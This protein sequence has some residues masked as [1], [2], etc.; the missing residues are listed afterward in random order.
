M[1]WT[2][3]LSAQQIFY[4]VF[5]AVIAVALHGFVT[6]GLARLLGDRG[7]QYDGRLTLNPFRHI[8]PIGMLCAVL[9]LFGWSRPPKIDPAELRFGRLALP[10]IVFA[11]ILTLIAFA[12]GLWALRPL[13]FSLMP[14][15]SVSYVAVGLLE[16]IAQMSVYMAV[17]N[18]LPL[19]PLGAGFLVLALAPAAYRWIEKR[20]VFFSIA[21]GA[22]CLFWAP[23]A[24][25]GLARSILRLVTGG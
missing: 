23:T 20:M 1:P 21:V 19:P 16:T 14:S 17:I 22:L 2:V 10:I 24:L 4:R 18:V 15:S 8:D 7:P 9:V 11:S 5:A 3:D 12:A 6:A 13:A 25:S